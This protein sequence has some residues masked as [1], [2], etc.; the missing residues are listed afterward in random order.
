MTDKIKQIHQFLLRL[1]GIL[2]IG[3]LLTTIIVAVLQ[4]ILR[5]VFSGGLVWADSMVRIMVLWLGLLGAMYASQSGNHIKIDLL[6]HYLSAKHRRVT[7]RMVN[8]FSGIVCSIVAWYSFKLVLLEYEDG[9]IA[10]G[11][12]PV[13]LCESIIPFAFMIMAARYLLDSIVNNSRN[14][15]K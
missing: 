5:N 3:I 6:T 7:G 13:W 10:F 2:L 11:N 12:I 4:I 15:N 1:E 8:L 9:A 14:I